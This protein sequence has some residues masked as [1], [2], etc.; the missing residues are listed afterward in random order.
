[1]RRDEKGHRIVYNSRNSTVP[2]MYCEIKKVASM[3][4][5]KYFSSLNAARVM[6]SYHYTGGKEKYRHRTYIPL[7]GMPAFDYGVFKEVR[8]MPLS[9]V[10]RQLSG[11]SKMVV[12]RHPLQRVVSAY[13]QV[14]SMST[15][16]GR[17]SSFQ[18]FVTKMFF[19][20]IGNVHYRPYLDACRPCAIDYNYI[21]RLE[22][23]ADELRRAN[24]D[25]GIDPR[26]TLPEFHI[27]NDSCVSESPYKYDS[28]LRELE[29]ANPNLFRRLLEGLKP[30]MDL[31]GYTWNNHSSGCLYKDAG[32]C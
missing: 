1:M 11:Y 30:D 12:V 14:K 25:I 27:R 22:N 8:H 29:A 28:I 6:R 2:L 19:A 4:H 7:K 23:E 3:S 9:V 18:Q 31:F 13:F 20:G 32:C 16:R 17:T 24:V 10:L 15:G 26:A 5:F 21:L